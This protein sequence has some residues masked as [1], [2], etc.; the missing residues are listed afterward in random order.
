[1]V[2]MDFSL[3]DPP[4]FMVVVPIVFPDPALG[5]R[6]SSHLPFDAHQCQAVADASTKQGLGDPQWPRTARLA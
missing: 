3:D 4:Q 1:M 5:W 6:R 2:A